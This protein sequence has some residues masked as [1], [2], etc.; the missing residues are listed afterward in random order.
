MESIPLPSTGM[1]VTEMKEAKA[2]PNQ[3]KPNRQD[4]S[5]KSLILNLHSFSKRVNSL[6]AALISKQ[7][8][9]RKFSEVLTSFI[10]SQIKSEI[11]H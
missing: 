6:P 2:K 7:E 10:F 5:T 11:S 9:S 1:S 3:T 8:Y 4:Y